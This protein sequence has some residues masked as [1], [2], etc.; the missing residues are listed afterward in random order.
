[1]TQGVA[2]SANV[3]PR[4]HRFPAAINRRFGFQAGVH[5]EVMQ[6]AVG[7]ELQQV[8]FIAFL[9]FKKGTIK[10]THIGERELL[11]CGSDGGRFAGG[12]RGCRFRRLQRAGRDQQR[13]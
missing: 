4:L 6:H 10:Q 1:M 7:F 12:L 5:A 9:S 8:R 2:V 13:A 11:E 3:R